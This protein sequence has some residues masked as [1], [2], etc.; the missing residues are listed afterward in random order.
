VQALGKLFQSMGE[1]LA[2]KAP[3]MLG[4]GLGMRT[5]PIQYSR[6]SDRHE[7]GVKVA[8]L[9]EF[10]TKAITTP[11]RKDPVV[12]TGILD[13]YGD[14][15]IHAETVVHKLD[16]KT[17]QR[18]WDLTGRQAN[19]ADFALDSKRVARGGIGWGCWSAHQELG[20]KRPYPEQMTGH[21]CCD[22]EPKKKG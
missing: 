11:G 1:G 18:S 3:Y 7:I 8:D 12:S 9:L 5:V 16:D 2:N 19:Q 4:K 13:S 22:G 20:D 15:F 14:R 10:K 17:I 6:S 21:D